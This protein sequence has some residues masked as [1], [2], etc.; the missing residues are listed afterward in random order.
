MKGSGQRD[1]GTDARSNS[2]DRAALLGVGLAA[3]I[4]LSASEGPWELIESAIGL[5]LLLLIMAFYNADRKGHARVSRAEAAAVS[6]VLAL[7]VCLVAAF[8][9]QRFARLSLDQL[10]N[11]WL[12]AVFV[13]SAVGSY[14]FRRPLPR[15][16][17]HRLYEVVRPSIWSRRLAE[18]ESSPPGAPTE[19]AESGPVPQATGH[20]RYRRSHR[21]R[22]AGGRHDEAGLE[23]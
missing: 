6:G 16:L 10:G 1:T 5:A 20:A 2:V 13:V 4:G 15:L 7:C 12:P 22:G 17:L 11:V 9:L 8:P 3:T 14:L 21:R 19:T 23:G 18:I